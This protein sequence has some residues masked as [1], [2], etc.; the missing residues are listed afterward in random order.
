M[1]TEVWVALIGAAA[2]IVTVIMQ[3]RKN[4][5]KVMDE[6]KL[7]QQESLHQQQLASERADAKMSEAL[8]VMEQK[9]EELTRETRRHNNFAEKIPVLEERIKTI[10]H[11]LGS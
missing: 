8:A 11:R 5:Q 10:N 2:T 7:Q 6:L 4:H 3:N 1:S 9:I